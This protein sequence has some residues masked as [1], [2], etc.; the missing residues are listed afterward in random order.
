VN[1]YYLYN[2][3]Y[4]LVPLAYGLGA[5]TIILDTMFKVIR[6]ATVL[7]SAACDV[8]LPRQTRAHNDG[9]RR[10]LILTTWMAAALA[11]LPCLLICIALAFFAEPMF[12]LLLGNS[13]VMPQAIANLMIVLLIANLIQTVSNFLLIH[14]GY[15]R[16]IAHLSILVS[17]AATVA[18]G[19]AILIGADLTGFIGAFTAIYVASALSYLTLALRGPLG[20]KN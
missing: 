2:F 8:A 18:T 12:R 11:S 15:F 3:A 4:A 14:T 6:G 16:V 1:E 17:V 10:S 19:I 7:Y 13:A 20:K 9:D 5:P